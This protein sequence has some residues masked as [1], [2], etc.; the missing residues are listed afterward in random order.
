VLHHPAEFA[1]F[2]P[3]TA[4][5]LVRLIPGFLIAETDVRRGLGLQDAN[6]LIDGR[7]VQGKANDV[8]DALGR[9]AVRDVLRI[10]VS[11]SNSTES[12]A[13]RQVANIIL[14]ETAGGPR[15]QFSWK[16]STRLRD[17]DPAWLNGDVS[18]SGTD[19]DL[20]Y[21]V[22]VRNTS[23]R[24]GASGPAPVFNPSGTLIE[25]RDEEYVER[26]D[27]PRI[28]ADIRYE[29]PGGAVAN[30]RGS[31][32]RQYYHFEELSARLPAG[33]V[34][35][36][37]TLSQTQS[38][39][40][41]EVAGDLEFGVGPGRLKVIVLYS[42]GTRPS[43]TG[44]STFFA[45][46]QPATG[47]RFVSSAEEREAVLRSEYRWG[48]GATSW[49]VAAEKAKNTLA[50]AST[51]S[52]LLPDGAYEETPFPGSSGNVREVRHEGLVSVSHRFS[53]RVS[54]QGALGAEHSELSLLGDFQSRRSFLRAKGSL[55]VGW[56]PTSKL[57]A[58]AKIE[59]RVGQISFFDFL[60][61]RNLT[62]ERENVGNPELVPPQ[63]WSVEAELSR[64]LGKLG[65]ST[66]RLYAQRIEDL[67]EQVP[68]GSFGEAPGNIDAALLFGVDWKTGLLLE[69]LGWAGARL[70]L[71]VQL[72]NSRVEDPVTGRSRQISNALVRF[73]DIEFRRDLPGTPWAWGAALSH[74]HRAPNF[75]IAELG[76]YRL[77]PVA[78]SVYV[79]N[80]D[81]AGLT[82]RASLGNLISSSQDLDRF[83]FDGRRDAGLSV[84]ERRRRSVGP[85]ATLSVTGAF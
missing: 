66:A 75:R 23:V 25:S 55:A 69:S 82:V 35:R 7:S 50:N 58:T 24:T 28:A 57:R 71:R 12:S 43:V 26:S 51:L 68:I 30:L 49:L 47:T 52:R 4:L 19:G 10:E 18:V 3:R 54:V 42:A 40:R 39:D 15:G 63:I 41:A 1:R 65:S 21:T 74:V 14:A 36:A 62:E 83:L 56:Q 2:N 70:D 13:G 16:P 77:G 85:T 46:G 22:G 31:Y 20:K 8:A 27:L 34:P 76:R 67:I 84:V 80:K 64:D 37:R 61:S 60:A 17:P 81:L 48:R 32:Q 9:I 45:D 78:G 29:P 72:Q 6:V 44:V 79:E 59:R 5:D 73:L 11:T 53:P 38:G 33:L